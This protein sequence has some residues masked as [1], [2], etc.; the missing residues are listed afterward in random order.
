MLLH[1]LKTGS[2]VVDGAAPG[3]KS[4]SRCTKPCS[5]WLEGMNMA[6][7]NVSENKIH[8]H[9][10]FIERRRTSANRGVFRCTPAYI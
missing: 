10:G 9:R 7:A 8:F 6:R 2:D 3:D 4:R 1:L 5:A